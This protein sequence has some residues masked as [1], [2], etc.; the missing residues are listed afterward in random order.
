MHRINLTYHYITVFAFYFILYLGMTSSIGEN[1]LMMMMTSLAPFPELQVGNTYI[2]VAADYFTRWVEA[3]PVPNQEATTVARRLPDEFF[4][5]FSPLEQLHADQG[6]QF[7]IK[8]I[9]E[10]CKCWA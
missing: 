2:L 7:E 9:A 4:F 1:P 8:I 10:I 3:Y 6:W 5:R